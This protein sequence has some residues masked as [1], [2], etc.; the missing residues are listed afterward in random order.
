MNENRREKRKKLEEAHNF[1]FTKKNI[2]R[3]EIHLNVTTTQTLSEVKMRQIVF[4]SYMCVTSHICSNLLLQKSKLTCSF[5]RKMF[6]LTCTKRVSLMRFESQQ[7]LELFHRPH[8]KI[9][10]LSSD[11]FPRPHPLQGSKLRMLLNSFS[12]YFMYFANPGPYPQFENFHNPS[13]R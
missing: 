5:F 4:Y 12:T 7:R 2:K 13:S 6:L 1:R 11:V 10:L 8:K 3:C 9:V